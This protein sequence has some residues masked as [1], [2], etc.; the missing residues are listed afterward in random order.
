MYYYPIPIIIFDG[1]EETPKSTLWR[2]PKKNKEGLLKNIYRDA[3][4]RGYKNPKKIGSDLRVDRRYPW[5][6]EVFLLIIGGLFVAEFGMWVF[7]IQITWLC[8]FGFSG[9]VVLNV[10]VS[11]LLTLLYCIEISTIVIEWIQFGETEKHF[12]IEVFGSK[13]F[14]AKYAEAIGLEMKSRRQG[15]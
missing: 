3:A 11:G 6:V 14:R 12:L 4:K 10:L 7:G 5:S 1:E 13:M 2:V 8:Q 9:I 15:P